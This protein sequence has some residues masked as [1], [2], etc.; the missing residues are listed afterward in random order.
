M[1][2][3]DTELDA[4]YDALYEQIDKDRHYPESEHPGTSPAFSKVTEEMKKRK[5]LA[6]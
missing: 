5:L 4:I 2:L 3:T 1:E 6:R